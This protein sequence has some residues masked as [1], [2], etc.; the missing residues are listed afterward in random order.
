MALA[1]MTPCLPAFAFP[2][3]PNGFLPQTTGL[4]LNPLLAWAPAISAPAGSGDCVFDIFGN[5]WCLAQADEQGNRHLLVLPAQAPEH[6]LH[7]QISYLQA[8]PWR[9]VAADEFGFIWIASS[10]LC[11]RLDPHTPENHW[12]DFSADILV[13]PGEKII[14]A[15]GIGPAGELVLAFQTGGIVRIDCSDKTRI[16]HLDS[17]AGVDT[18]LSDNTGQIWL[19]C[20]DKTYS[21]APA[22][23]V[24][25]Q[26][27][28]LAARL[29]AGNHDLSG[30]VL[31]GRF[32]MAGGQNAGWGY[33]ARPHVFRELYE[34]DPAGRTW[35]IAAQLDQPRF[36]NGTSC[37]D[38][39]VWVIGGFTRDVIGNPVLLSSVEIFDPATGTSVKGP[40]LPTAMANPVALKLNNRIYVAA[41]ASMDA[42]EHPSLL[43][44]ISSHETAWR[45]EP[46]GPSYKTATAGT[47]LGGHVYLALGGKGLSRFDP[48]TSSWKLIPYPEP[49]RSPQIA[50]FNDEI[51]VLGGRDITHPLRTT[52]YTPKTGQWRKGPNL[53]RPLSWGAAATVGGRLM[54][55]GGAGG[56]AYNNRTFL[57]RQ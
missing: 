29:P 5:H 45:R 22:P 31:E 46:D 17:P 19:R 21:L 28:E 44:S 14:S 52:I 25:Q 53:P 6:W 49:A 48:A 26:T 37:L 55:V 1:C 32:Y 18:I 20:G 50:A 27:W 40:Q 7:D 47:V 24:W 34:Y 42:F 43:Y 30:D 16:T 2:D 13:R 41:F 54:L 57:L 11:M 56:V 39:K 10:N 51:W 23:D 36:Y 4:P 15:M 12:M 38:G 3:E 8:A 35:R 9:F 33:P